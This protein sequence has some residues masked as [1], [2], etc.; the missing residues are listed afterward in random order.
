MRE[1]TIEV[2]ED[3]SLFV[4]DILC[5]I[6]GYLAGKGDDEFTGKITLKE[7]KDIVSDLNVELKKKLL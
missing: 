2:R 7:A 1:I 6:D 3:V 4:S 5:W